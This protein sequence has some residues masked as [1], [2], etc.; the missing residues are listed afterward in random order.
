MNDQN[1]DKTH[2]HVV[3]TKGTMVSHYLIVEKIGE[4][5]SG[6]AD[7]KLPRH[8]VTGLWKCD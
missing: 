1:D 7:S 5:G 3:L 8:K 6:L 4:G 2:T